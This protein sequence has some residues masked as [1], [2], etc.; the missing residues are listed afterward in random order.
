MNSAISMT[1][2][3]VW[4]GA[5]EAAM[6]FGAMVGTLLLSLTVF[7]QGNS[8]RVLGTVTDQSG[9]AVANATVTVT[10]VQTG[11]A[12]NLTTDDVGEYV[13]PNLLP[14]T[15]SVRAAVA[16]F[17][18]LER[19][20]IFLEVGKDIRVDLQLSP[21][22]VT[23]T[24][25]VTSTVP[26][27]DSTSVTLGGTL[28]NDTINDLPLNGRNYINLLSLRPGVEQYPGGG[29]WT[30]AS[31]GLR[32][33]DQNWIV[34]GLDNNE[35][36]QGQPVINSPGTA[37][38]SAT[39]LPIDA[40]QE[41]NVEE[42]PKAE[43]GWRPGAVV[44]V[45]LKSGT[46]RLHGSAYAFGRT[47]AWDAKNYYTPSAS[48]NPPLNF[49]QWG[50]TAGGPI[51][52]DKL[53]FFA[54]FEEQR[55]AVGNAS[56]V[57]IPT[58]VAG[59]GPS[60]S[61][62]D[63]TADL[64][65]HGITTLNPLSLKLLPLYGATNSA[66]GQV[67]NEF[68]ATNKS[69]NVLAKID[70]T[71]N[72]HHTLSGSYF[73]GNDNNVSEDF[74]FIT[75]P[76]FMTKFK[77]RTMAA[78]GRWIFTP[79]SSWVNEIRFGFVR[80]NRPVQPVDSAVP[81]TKYGINTG[82]T[83]PNALGMPTIRVAGLGQLGAFMVWPNL[84][85]PDNNFDFLD[86][87]SYLHGRHAFKF[88]AEI[89]YARITSNAHSNGRGQFR[90]VGGQ[91]FQG[92]TALEDFLAGDPAFA[93][94]IVGNPV[95]YYRTTS[96]GA[97]V[98][99]DWR[100][101]P[102]VTVN[103]GLRWEYTNPISEKNDLLAAFVP[104]SPT[105]MVQVGQGI[106]S[107][108][109]RSKTN[110]APRFG[111][112]WDISGNGTTVI[113]AGGGLF[114]DMLPA[115]VL[116]D[117]APN[118][119][120]IHP[121]GIAKTP[122]G[123]L[124]VLPN[125]STVQGTGTIATAAFNYPGAAL[126]WTLAGPVLPSGGTVACGN[127]V[128]TIPGPNGT[129]LTPQPCGIFAV[130]R[131]F[132]T[133][134][135]GIWTLTLQ[136]AFSS[137]LS[138]E[139]AYIGNHGDDL[140]G[141]L[142]VNQLDPTSAGEIACRHCEAIASRPYGTP[143]PY[144]NFIDQV[145]NPYIS[146]YHGLQM[147]L[148]GRHFHNLSFVAGYT[149][150]HALD[151]LTFSGLNFTPQDSRNVRAQYGNSDFDTRHR[152]TLT[153]SYDI[154]GKKGFGQVLEGWQLNSIV[155]LAGSQPWWA[156]DTTQDISATGEKMDRWDFFGNPGDF[157]SSGVAALPYCTGTG[158]GG[159]TQVFANG[160]ATTFAAA[161]SGA[162]FGACQAAAAKVANGPGG[163]T[164][165]QSLNAFG[166]YVNGKSVLVPPAIGTF[167]TM[168]RNIFQDTGFK[169]W[170]LSVF[171]TFKFKERLTAQFRVEAFNVL[172][173]P[174]FANPYTS[175]NGNGVGNAADPSAPGLFG[176]SGFVTPDV[177]AT[178]PILGSGGGRDVQLGLKLIF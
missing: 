11:V 60:V 122:T 146:N 175:I 151:D 67:F 107:P 52:K 54:G 157:K 26:L 5:R 117:Q 15:Y 143:Y 42:N 83:D 129:T 173:H 178:N 49:E 160:T 135:V 70:Y 71:M 108:Y 79:N 69:D 17:K 102:K 29:A 37:G 114:Y 111:V 72:A 174:N 138:F 106:S 101:K 87:L 1:S 134:Y 47:D 10:N 112:A 159:C 41:F 171:K 96:D 90:F 99:D 3:A 40:I 153:T 154:P 50:G 147:S 128:S 24:V 156:F 38:D 126:N 22:D 75:Q 172:N 148:T 176:S 155:T 32:V 57:T 18:A 63:A 123:A 21:G 39:I 119:Q 94:A 78:T 6:A 84:L 7:P 92:S 34:D 136:H 116:L 74:P 61:L 20:N 130:A 118:L 105:G 113:R 46:N 53:F 65:A 158:N 103:V 66:S 164:G 85:G 91:A 9:A 144:L 139:A 86:Q 56:T 45:G 104:G 76:E 110:F 2:R 98:Q 142:D 137:S 120:N 73:F 51:V 25:E 161:Q 62:P 55:Y 152:F 93:F 19:Q 168:G 170:D 109:N 13:A 59:G 68:T 127:G 23:Q 89:R 30:Q 133:P 14:G 58:P 95:R 12:R 80:Y 140:S 33:E 165:L 43:Y 177:A 166:C 145:R 31:N 115:G 132:S 82:V 16:G 81:A 141:V 121:P 48:P 35:S 77:I 88:G 150:S 64:A 149:Y 27:I 124:L 163:T 8:G 97:F 44:N 100:I 167:G 131:N 162:M 28:G 4:F 36:N 169:N 125:G